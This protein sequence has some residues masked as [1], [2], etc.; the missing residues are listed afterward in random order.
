M[1]LERLLGNIR[2]NALLIHVLP[3]QAR[4]APRLTRTYH[5]KCGQ[6]GSRRC[7][8]YLQFEWPSRFLPVR[9]HYRPLKM[10]R[11]RLFNPR[12]VTLP[13]F[14]LDFQRPS[15]SLERGTHFLERGHYLVYPVLGHLERERSQYQ[16]A[17]W[18]PLSTPDSVRIIWSNGHSG[19]VINA[20][21]D[22][23]S[24][25]GTATVLRDYAALGHGGPP[26]PPPPS[27]NVRLTSTI[28]PA[29]LRSDTIPR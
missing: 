3:L 28:C 2:S 4:V 21:R 16:G 22:G 1:E 8:E 14:P 17:Y 26:L 13:T 7:Q 6:R 5:D 19:V 11:L 29:R 25:R 10:S 9:R 15:F 20:V 27:R 24:L 12:P 23:T 18:L